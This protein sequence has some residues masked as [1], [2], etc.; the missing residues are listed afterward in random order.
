VW[1]GKRDIAGGQKVT[2]GKG[3]ETECVYFTFGLLGLVFGMGSVGL[4]RFGLDSFCCCGV[5]Q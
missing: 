2:G 5:A 1:E 4:G 3:T